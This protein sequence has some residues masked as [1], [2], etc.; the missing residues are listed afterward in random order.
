MRIHASPR[1]PVSGS[2]CSADADRAAHGYRSSSA[3]GLS[4]CLVDQVDW[5]VGRHHRCCVSA[6]LTYQCSVRRTRGSA[7]DRPRGDLL[8]FPWMKSPSRTGSKTL[9][10]MDCKSRS[11]NSS[12]ERYAARLSGRAEAVVAIQLLSSSLYLLHQAITIKTEEEKMRLAYLPELS[13]DR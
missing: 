8:L 5:I 10:A 3:V 6:Q 2:L 7:F 12:L 11:T 9:A 4:E 13:S 1:I